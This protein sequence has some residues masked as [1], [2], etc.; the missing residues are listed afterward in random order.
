MNNVMNIAFLL[1]KSKADSLG[2]APLYA[3]I[4]INNS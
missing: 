4:T 2:Y 3:R 1:K